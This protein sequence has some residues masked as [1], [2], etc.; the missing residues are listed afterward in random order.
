M[1]D[2]TKPK[3]IIDWDLIEADWRANVKTKQQMASEYGVSRAAMDKRFTKLGIARDLGAKVRAKA[4]ALVAQAAVTQAV[5]PGTTVT[6]RD[7]IEVNA[8]VQSDIMIAHR[9]DIQRARR[10]TMSLLDELE[11]QVGHVDLYEQLGELLAQPDKNGQDKRL[12]LFT[13]AMS[14]SSRTGT[15]KGLADS[16]KTLIA[17]E[18]Q[19]FGVDE[20]ENE[21]DGGIE[22]VIRRVLARQGE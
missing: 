9:T 8:A 1:T 12:E 6:E 16:L 19:A 14:L 5:T 10:V 18:R 21:G 22:S 20:R 15:M 17:M 7:I 13:K 11:H 2:T 4:E 3:R